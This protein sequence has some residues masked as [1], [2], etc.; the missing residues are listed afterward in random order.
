MANP[1]TPSGFSSIRCGS[2]G[3]GKEN[4]SSP[5]V[6]KRSTTVREM[7]GSGNSSAGHNGGVRIE[8]EI[9]QKGG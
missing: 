3:D 1:M 7:V 5:V 2:A 9:Y 6:R 4:V 8:I